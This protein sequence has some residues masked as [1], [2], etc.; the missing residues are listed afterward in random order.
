ME[1]SN[2]LVLIRTQPV[3]CNFCDEK[4]CKDSEKI[5]HGVCNFLRCNIKDCKKGS[6]IFS[7]I[8]FSENTTLTVSFILKLFYYSALKLQV[9]ETVTHIGCH[10]RL[11]LIIMRKKILNLSNQEF[12]Y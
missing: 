11:L 5:R 8:F 2:S 6:L 4:L 10:A 12:L 7:I 1:L 9:S 3:F